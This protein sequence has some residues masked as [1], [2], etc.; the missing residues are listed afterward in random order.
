M[1][2]LRTAMAVPRP[3]AVTATRMTGGTGQGLPVCMVVLV[4]ASLT[5]SV[6]G[7]RIWTC[8]TKTWRLR[9]EVRW[10]EDWLAGLLDMGR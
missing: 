3:R 5:S 10:L 4:A 7:L 2:R 9:W 1:T 8:M 6:T